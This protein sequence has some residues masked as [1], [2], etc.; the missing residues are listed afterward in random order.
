VTTFL[1]RLYGHCF[2]DELMLIYP[3]YAVMFVDDGLTPLQ[4][5]TLFAA[6]SAT[7][8]LLEVPSGVLADRHSRKTIMVAGAVLRATGYGCWALFPGFW[9][10]LVGFVL[11]GIEGALGSGAFEALVY[12]ELK[13]F[14]RE[15]EYARILGRCRSLGLIGVVVSGL[16]A[17]I[18]VSAGYVVLI[19]ASSTAALVAGVLLMSLPTAAPVATV[20]GGG[21]RAYV[22]T[23]QRG[24]GSV[25]LRRA[26]CHIV[27]FAALARALGGTLEEYWPIFISEMGMAPFALGLFMSLMCGVQA[28]A[29]FV[30]HR[31]V[32]LP[33]RPIFAVFALSGLLLSAAAWS[34]HI[35]AIGLILLFVFVFQAVDIIYDARLQSAIASDH[36][37]TASS[38]K[39][40]FSEVGGIIL[41]MSMGAIVTNGSYQIG[42][43]WFGAAIGVIGLVFLLAGSPRLDVDAGGAEAHR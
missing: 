23:L 34:M 3:F 15:S 18:A 17:S 10:F 19:A 13:H 43:L 21:F 37:A 7:T 16:I 6:W 39:S 28:F 9:G 8:L 11:W 22:D 12:D 33:S 27:V 5:S 29:S 30:A 35:A 32:D 14:G 1:I 4:V 42:F 31:F 2:V 38:V 26:V 25:V 24:V 20:G 40:L 41:V 36:R